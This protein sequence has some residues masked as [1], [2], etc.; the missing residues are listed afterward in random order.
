MAGPQGGA[1]GQVHG[2]PDL[3][4]VLGRLPKMP[5]EDLHIGDTVMI[6]AT[7]GADGGHGTVINLLAGVEAI[8][9]ATPKGSQPMT[10]SPWNINGSPGDASLAQ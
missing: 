5:I 8:L 6:V 4:Q 10:L 9:A 2:V 7:P 3:Q 1:G